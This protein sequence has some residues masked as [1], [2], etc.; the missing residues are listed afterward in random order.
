[1]SGKKGDSLQVGRKE[2]AS[3]LGSC[4]VDE[5]DQKAF[6]EGYLEQF[7]AVGLDASLIADQKRFE[8]ETEN[9]TVSVAPDRSDLVEVKC[10]NGRRMITIWVEGDITVNGIEVDV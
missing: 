1:M 8:I 3:L 10:V 5:K 7:G 6:D 9:V 4:D 2:I